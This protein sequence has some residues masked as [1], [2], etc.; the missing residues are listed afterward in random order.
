MQNTTRKIISPIFEK[1][2]EK[3]L[4]IANLANGL[5]FLNE[6]RHCVSLYNIHFSIL[7]GSHSLFLSSILEI[8]EYFGD[9]FIFTITLEKLQMIAIAPMKSIFKII[10]LRW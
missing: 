4:I 10:W 2:F 3:F 6:V 5:D 1:R 8:N 7:Y 9:H